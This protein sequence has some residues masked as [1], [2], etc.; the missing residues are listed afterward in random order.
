MIASWEEGGEK[1]VEGVGCG[2]SKRRWWDRIRVFLKGEKVS[3]IDEFEIQVGVAPALEYSI[4]V[5]LWTS[6]VDGGGSS[7]VFWIFA[8]SGVEVVSKK[9]NL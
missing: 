5:F 8:L 7:A 6:M 2:G 1:A 9:R 3:S 4:S